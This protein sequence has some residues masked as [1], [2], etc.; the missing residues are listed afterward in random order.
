[1][2][3]AGKRSAAK[4]P[5][6]A[7]PAKRRVQAARRT[8][9]HK[10]ERCLEAHVYPYL[11]KQIVETERVDGKLL[12]DAVVEAMDDADRH[13]LG[14]LFW[15]ELLRKYGHRTSLLAQLQP[16]DSKETVADELLAALQVATNID[17]KMRS[18]DS[19]TTYL[20]FAPKLNENETMGGRL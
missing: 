18:L 2:G 11:S 15:R 5:D 6:I 8:P 4:A 9:D 1:M 10:I 7:T 16:K 20:G 14:A 12:R 13:R 19:L 3:P 17:N